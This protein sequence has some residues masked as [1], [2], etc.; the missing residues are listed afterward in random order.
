MNSRYDDLLD[1]ETHPVWGK[2]LKSNEQILWEG[3][4]Q[5]D[6]SIRLLDSTGYHDV[7][8]GASSNFILYLVFLFVLARMIYGETGLVSA[9][10]FLFFGSGLVLIFE[11]LKNKS[12]EKIRYAVTT[13]FLLI[14]YDYFVFKKIAAIPLA[15]V[16]SISPIKYKDDT[17][18]LLFPNYNER[19][20]KT[21]DFVTGKRR[22]HT[23]FEHIADGEKVL[24]LISTLIKDN[25][26][27]LLQ[28]QHPMMS[29]RV[30]SVTRKIYQILLVITVLYVVDFYLL[31]KRTITDIVIET[32]IKTPRGFNTGGTHY[33]E[34]GL[35]FSTD[36]VYT[37]YG[38][39]S[40]VVLDYSPV[41]KSVTAVKTY[42]MD[43]TNRLDS[44]LNALGKYAALICFITLLS[45][46][47][48]LSKTPL[49]QESY[50]QLV[51][52]TMFFMIM[53]WVI[54]NWL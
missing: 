44:D 51:V 24:K 53:F 12:N 49:S 42:R 21:I 38:D 19:R 47:F 27:S 37:F 32:V 14:K 4:P 16:I 7:M 29:E 1:E 18:T 17:T 11:L 33:T 31:P 46:I 48:I 50:M 26:L 45:G 5:G 36:H 3:S 20:I 52:C 54:N 8:T 22:D 9:L 6:M 41:F 15:K 2:Y 40:E 39:E 30:V 28:Y 35:S 34:K 25:Q 10:P 13:H 23:S 43:Y